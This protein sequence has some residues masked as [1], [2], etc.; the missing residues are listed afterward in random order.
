MKLALYGDLHHFLLNNIDIL[1]WYQKLSILKSIAWNLMNLHQ[2]DI[3]HCDFH[4]GNIING[5]VPNDG[6]YSPC[7]K[8]SDFGVSKLADTSYNH[9]QIYG[10]IPYVAPEVLEHGYYTKRSDIYSLGMIM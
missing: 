1:S 10:I 9:S 6:I 8:I 5:D 3:I 4:G 2:K 7:A